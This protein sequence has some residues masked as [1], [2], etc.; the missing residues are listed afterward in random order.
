MYSMQKLGNMLLFLEKN[1]VGVEN[2]KDNDEGVNRFEEMSLF[3]NVVN[4]KR[5]EKDIDKKP[6]LYM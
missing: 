3:T 2:V 1:I 5:I 4:I 6:M